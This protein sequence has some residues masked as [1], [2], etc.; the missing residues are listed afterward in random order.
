[1]LPPPWSER[2]AGDTDGRT[3][4]ITP[5]G[6]GYSGT[7]LFQWQSVKNAASYILHVQRLSD[8]Q[9]VIRQDSLTTNTHT[10]ATP[11]VSGRYRVWVQAISS[12]GQPGL[13]SIPA[14][15]TVA[16]VI[17]P[18]AAVSPLQ[19]ILTVLPTGVLD[20]L[21]DDDVQTMAASV[22]SS[23]GRLTESKAV[24][25]VRKNDTDEA[26]DTE[27]GQTFQTPGMSSEAADRPVTVI[28]EEPEDF[29]LVDQLMSG[30]SEEKNAA[31]NI[32]G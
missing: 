12:T 19:H 3:S 13:W 22:E 7:P 25:S 27:T 20:L 29:T 18:D 1:M 26:S 15:F 10:P 23:D 4:L 8:G 31:G 9:V 2:A 24:D 16:S 21:A 14:D 28:T 30:L 5:M 32:S 17:A 11:L 6:P